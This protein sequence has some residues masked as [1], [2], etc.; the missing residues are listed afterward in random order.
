MF[1]LCNLYIAIL[2]IFNV[3][4]YGLRYKCQNQILINMSKE[5][6]FKRFVPDSAVEISYNTFL[7]L[8]QRFRQLYSGTSFRCQ[9]LYIIYDRRLYFLLFGVN[10]RNNVL[11]MILS[12]QTSEPFFS[13]MWMFFILMIFDFM[14]RFQGEMSYVLD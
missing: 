14:I 9:Y 11:K 1:V 4:R 2:Y 7:N 12:T 10:V 3:L 8:L 5:L 13:N 6:I